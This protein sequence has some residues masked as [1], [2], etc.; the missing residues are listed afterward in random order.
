MRTPARHKRQ[1]GWTCPQLPCRT[2]FHAF[3]QERALN[4]KVKH[5]AQLHAQHTRDVHGGPRSVFSLKLFV[6]VF[7]KLGFPAN[8]P[9]LNPLDYHVWAAWQNQV[10]K[11]LKERFAGH[12][13]NE[14]EMK[15]AVYTAWT[16][17]DQN[18]VKRSIVS[19]PKR[20][21]MCIEKESG[22][23]EYARVKLALQTEL[24]T[25]DAFHSEPR[26]TRAIKHIVSLRLSS[27]TI[28]TQ[29]HT[30][31]TTHTHTDTH[32]KAELHHARLFPN[33]VVS[34]MTPSAPFE[35]SKWS[36]LTD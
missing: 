5:G 3:S 30:H 18:A 15:A 17:V 32:N 26:S 20:L 33:G 11:M 1:H 14:M 7:F 19:W 12:A 9:D 36:G 24:F 31:T 10:N 34:F 2:V 25:T 23:F 16:Q 4:V 13:K 21:L 8:S 27:H 6:Q 35:K 22:S 29:Q 28:T